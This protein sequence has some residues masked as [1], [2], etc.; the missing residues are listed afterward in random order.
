MYLVDYWVYC[1]IYWKSVEVSC[2][3]WLSPTESRVHFLVFNVKVLRC[4]EMFSNSFMVSSSFFCILE[5][6]DPVHDIGVW[7]HGS[8]RAFSSRALHPPWLQSD[9]P[10]ESPGQPQTMRYLRS[11]MRLRSFSDGSRGPQA[12]RTRLSL[13]PAPWKMSVEKKKTNCAICAMCFSKRR[14][15]T[16]SPV[17][18]RLLILRSSREEN[19]AANGKDW[20]RMTAAVTNMNKCKRLEMEMLKKDCWNLKWTSKLPQLANVFPQVS[21]YS[22]LVQVWRIVCSVLRGVSKVDGPSTP[23]GM[24]WVGMRGPNEDVPHVVTY[25]NIWVIWRSLIPW[26]QLHGWSMASE[27][28]GDTSVTWKA[29]AMKRDGFKRR[30]FQLTKRGTW[31]DL[32]FEMF[33]YLARYL[34][35]ILHYL[36]TGIIFNIFILN[37]KLN[38]KLLSITIY[39]ENYH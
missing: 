20:P 9:S 6:F 11:T 19:T 35:H 13:H 30:S 1:W 3:D 8:S 33:R 22:C 29:D 7:G 2:V 14:P 28:V 23:A 25:G 5:M 26:K 10:G 15:S 39:H 16:L 36:V 21:T 17:T 34:L 38:I 4:L 32:T 12:F 24:A 18:T 37:V 31:Q 27:E